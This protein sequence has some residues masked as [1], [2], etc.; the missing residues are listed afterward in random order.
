MLILSS[1]DLEVIE[2]HL[3][4]APNRVL[5]SL[6]NDIAPNL[7]LDFWLKAFLIGLGLVTISLLIREQEVS[8]T[9]I[10]RVMQSI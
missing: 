6:I 1:K 4:V 5:V 9:K 7:A 10:L 8:D 3:Q 2:F